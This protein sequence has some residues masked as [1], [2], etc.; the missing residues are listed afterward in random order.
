MLADTTS[1]QEVYLVPKANRLEIVIHYLN[2][3]KDINT[4]YRH[5]IIRI[6]LRNGEMFALDL[7]GAQYGYSDPLSPWERYMGDRVRD[8]EDMKP[9]GCYR[10]RSKHLWEPQ[11]ESEGVKTFNEEVADVIN[12]AIDEWEETRGRLGKMLRL[13]QDNFIR[14]RDDLFYIIEQSIE[15]KRSLL[16][17][18]GIRQ[19]DF[20]SAIEATNM[21]WS[22][23]TAVKEEDDDE[24]VKLSWQ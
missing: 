18:A 1:L 16:E 10:K 3:E 20:E 9:L 12:A 5:A 24:N 14:Q 15:A 17:Q 8:I 6:T 7:S 22:G 21:M 4:S 19:L 2:G 23:K 13:E 11:C